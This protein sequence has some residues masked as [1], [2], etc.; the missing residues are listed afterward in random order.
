V[1]LPWSPPGRLEGI[2]RRPLA[3]R[4]AERL[5]DVDLHLVATKD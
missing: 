2:V 4:I 1:F 5:P 3:A